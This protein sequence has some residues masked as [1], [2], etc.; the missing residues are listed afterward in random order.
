M[1]NEPTEHIGE[2]LIQAGNSDFFLARNVFSVPCGCQMSTGFQRRT[3]GDDQ[4]V[5]E[6]PICALAEAFSDMARN[7]RGRFGELLVKIEISDQFRSLQE[8]RNCSIPSSA[9]V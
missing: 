1:R 9:F 5:S 3:A 8:W 4:I 7:F 6:V 2:V